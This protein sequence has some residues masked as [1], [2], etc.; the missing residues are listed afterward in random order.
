MENIV[1]PNVTQTLTLSN[2][3]AS[4]DYTI[5]GYCLEQVGRNS[6]LKK[7]SFST[8]SNGGYVSTIDFEFE[9]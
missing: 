6:M 8:D 7:V 3:M 1:T 5:E 2:L 4:T 9:S